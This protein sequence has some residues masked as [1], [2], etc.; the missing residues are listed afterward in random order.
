VEVVD[1]RNDLERFNLS[2]S[3]ISFLI[4]QWVRAERDR[5][6]LKDRLINGMTFERIAER[7]E[8]SVRQTKT[9]VYRAMERLISHL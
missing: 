1:L 6:I 2:N 8:M 4:E 5:A 9:I 7:H 3:Q